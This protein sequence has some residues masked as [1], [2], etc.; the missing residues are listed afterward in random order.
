MKDTTR[1]PLTL[2]LVLLVTGL[3]LATAAHRAGP[4]PGDL[5]LT[6]VLQ[7]ALPADGLLGT[8]LR[9]SGQL[10]WALPVLTVGIAAVRQH[11]GSALAL[12]VAGVTGLLVG[13]MVLPPLVARPRP[14]PALVRVG[15]PLPADNYGFPS[16]TVLVAVVFSGLLSSLVWQARPAARRR[17]RLLALGTGAVLML[18]LLLLSLSRVYVGAHWA[19]DVVGGWVWGGAW[20]LLLLLGQRWWQR[21]RAR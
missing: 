2:C 4:L 1:L 17:P 11:W 13:E 8:L 16:G 18:A 15:E 20:L 9:S 14:S 3:L 12:V 10:V 7:Q 6:R 19:T 5:T 21:R